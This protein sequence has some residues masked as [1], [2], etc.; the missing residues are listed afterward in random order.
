MCYVRDA[1]D[2]PD[3]HSDNA[4]TRRSLVTN[5]DEFLPSRGVGEGLYDTDS[6]RFVS[7]AFDILIYQPRSL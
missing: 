2:V 4:P 6:G 3:L 7:T 1:F 5:N